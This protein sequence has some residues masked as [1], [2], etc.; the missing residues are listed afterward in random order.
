MVV[1]SPFLKTHTIKR[2]HDVGNIFPHVRKDTQLRYT[3]FLSTETRKLNRE[4]SQLLNQ[5]IT[6]FLIELVKTARID[7][8]DI[9]QME[10]CVKPQQLLEITITILESK[11]RKFLNVTVSNS[12]IHP[13]ARTVIKTTT[14]LEGFELAMPTGSSRKENVGSQGGRIYGCIYA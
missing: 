13:K 8:K 7:F 3:L 12:L 6:K 14:L 5:Q 4:F 2:S 10:V 9:S 1:A 11:M